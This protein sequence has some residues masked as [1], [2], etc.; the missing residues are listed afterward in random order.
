MRQSNGVISKTDASQRG[1]L[2]MDQMTRALRSQ[3]CLDLGSAT[4]RPALEAANRNSMTFYTDLSDGS[5]P[6]VRARS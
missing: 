6:P 2:A 3:V 5:R 4:A 1:R